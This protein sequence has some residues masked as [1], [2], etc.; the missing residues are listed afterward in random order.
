MLF[1][2]AMDVLTALV[3]KAMELGILSSY[4][5]TM[6][7]QRV[8]IYVDDVVMFVKPSL[9]DFASIRA[10]LAAFREASGLRVNYHNSIA[11]LIRGD[12]DDRA[13]VTAI[14]QCDFS[15][16]PCCYLGLQLAIKSLT[17]AEWQPMPDQ[18]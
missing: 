8:S 17:Q 12:D 1:V 9:K 7:M 10:I 13:R 18:V 5:G 11:V 3:H 15:E 2:I 6:A 14:L 16:F 4:Y